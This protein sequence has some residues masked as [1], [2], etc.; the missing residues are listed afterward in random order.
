MKWYLRRIGDDSVVLG[1]MPGSDTT[2]HLE[3]LA[4]I[5]VTPEG[6][7]NLCISALGIPRL[8]LH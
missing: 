3:G 8:G 2:I 4:H 7:G 1:G 6:D 5:Y